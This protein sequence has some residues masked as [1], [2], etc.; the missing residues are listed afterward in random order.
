MCGDDGPAW[1]AKL[2]APRD[3]AAAPDGSLVVADTGNQVIRRIA[4]DGTISTIAG[5]G[6]RGPAAA[7]VER[8]ARGSATRPAWRSTATGSVLVADTGN[9][10]LRRIA[11]TGVVTTIV[12]R[13]LVR[14]TDVVVL[15]DGGYAVADPGAHRVVRVQ[16]D[17]SL[18]LLAGSG[19]PGFAGDGGPAD[20]ARAATT[21]GRR[22]VGVRTARRRRGERRRPADRARRHDHDARGRRPSRRAPGSWVPVRLRALRGVAATSAGDVVL[23][24]AGRLWSVGPDGAVRVLAGAGPSGFNGDGTD[25]LGT[26]LADTSGLATGADDAI[27]VSDAGNDRIRTVT[28]AGTIAT[29]AGSDQPDARVAPVAVAPFRRE[30]PR[31][32]PIAPRYYRPGPVMQSGGEYGGGAPAAPRPPAAPSCANPNTRLNVMKFYPYSDD[33]IRSASKPVVLTVGTSIDVRITGFAVRGGRDFG[34]VEVDRLAGVRTIRLRGRLRP[35]TYWA[36]ILGAAR[37]GTHGCD[38]RRLRVRR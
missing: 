23:G 31:T 20:E 25:A 12:S 10:A 6:V 33:R 16:A 4:A 38:S 28:T 37:D 8:G 27:L 14:P 18:G 24:D 2:A 21:D 34:R 26:R 36:V 19:A 1:R 5:F 30:R 7:R 29:L 35:G 17:G 32:R 22:G 13:R 3:V 9:H 11:V 15:P